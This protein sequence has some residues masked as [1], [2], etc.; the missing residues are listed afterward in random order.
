L[1][2]S[3]Y[4]HC[5]LRGGKAANFEGGIRVNAFVSGGVIPVSQ[6]GRKLDGL[7][8][9]WDW[10]ATFARLAGVDPIDHRA[11]KAGLP[12]IDSIDVSEYI[13]GH[14][15]ASPRKEMIVGAPSG[16]RDIW[17]GDH[18][19]TQVNGVIVDEGDAGLWKLMVGA[20]SMD[21]WTGP[22]YPNDT[23]AW[24]AENSPE[25]LFFDCGEGCLWRL[26]QDPTEH[27][28]VSKHPANAKR[29]AQMKA[30][31][32]AAN[33][34]TFSPNRGQADPLACTTAKTKWNNFWGPFLP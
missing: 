2:I 29:I 10:Y 25:Q 23:A 22:H 16:Y 18:M 6:R 7:I 5:P 1:T 34:T 24:T 26:D 4:G 12:S 3:L 28:D 13:L 17:G 14:S 11:A 27:F 33:A 30:A 32:E 31:A 8:T 20:L 21:V 19:E 15:S 9:L